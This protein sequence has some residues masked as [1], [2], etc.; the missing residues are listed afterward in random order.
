[1]DLFLI[2]CLSLPYCL[3]C[4][5][6]PCGHLLGNGWPLGSPVFDVSGAFVTFLYGVLGQLWCLIV[7]IPDLCLLPYFLFLKTS[8]FSCQMFQQKSRKTFFLKL[9]SK[10]RSS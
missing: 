3:V 4:V 10:C 8:I 2:L 7:S 1:M 5:L 6:Q 9:I